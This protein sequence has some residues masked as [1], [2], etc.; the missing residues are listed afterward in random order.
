M[1]SYLGRY[2]IKRFSQTP[3]TT[4]RCDRQRDMFHKLIKHRDIL[5]NRDLF[6]ALL[7]ILFLHVFTLCHPALKNHNNLITV[8]STSKRF[9]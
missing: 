1:Y 8:L 4:R 9:C 6:A 2:T 5:K 3:F 7:T